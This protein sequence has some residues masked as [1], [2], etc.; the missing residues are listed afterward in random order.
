[1]DFI[2]EKK[3]RHKISRDK[4]RISLMKPVKL[5]KTTSL[6]AGIS[7][8]ET[9]GKSAGGVSLPAKKTGGVSL[10]KDVAKKI[11]MSPLE[12]EE[13]MKKFLNIDMPERSGE[14]SR[15]FSEASSKP[16]SCVDL[17][18]IVKTQGV[19]SYEGSEILDKV[20]EFFADASTGGRE[21]ALPVLIQLIVKNGKSI[22]PFVVPLFPTLLLLH[23]DRSTSVRDNAAL[24]IHELS[25]VLCPHAFRSLFPQ[26]TEAMKN[27]DWRIKVGALDAIKKMSPRMAF[28]I[29][30]LLCELIPLASECVIDSKKQVSVP[31]LS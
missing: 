1:M 3:K 12:N 2:S 24:V 9:D 18:V 25:R 17:A 13:G 27:E 8:M 19:C 21:T 23:A 5:T 16:A 31:R 26:I 14:I 6:P 30:P 4:N 7:K 22:E 11:S 28:Q 20:L 29:S 15:L 10:N